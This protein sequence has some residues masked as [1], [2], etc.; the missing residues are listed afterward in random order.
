LITFWS[1][2]SFNFNT[3]TWSNPFTFS[4]WCFQSQT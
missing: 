3:T 2:S 4:A 1:I